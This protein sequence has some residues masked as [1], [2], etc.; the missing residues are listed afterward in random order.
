MPNTLVDITTSL[1][2]KPAPDINTLS[3]SANATVT[4][5]TPVSGTQPEDKLNLTTTAGVDITLPTGTYKLLSNDDGIVLASNVITF[6]I[7]EFE[8]SIQNNHIVVMSWDLL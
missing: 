2:L 4:F 1:E 7:G 5:E 3:L 8:I 6:P